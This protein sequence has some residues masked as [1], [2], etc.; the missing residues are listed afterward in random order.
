MVTYQTAAA[1]VL[2]IVLNL[3]LIPGYSYIG[4]SV[5]TVITEFFAF[6][7]LLYFTMKTKYR[8]SRKSIY[9]IIK[10]LISGPL[11]LVLFLG[12]KIDTLIS[13]AIFFILYPFIIYLLRVLD[14]DDIIILKKLIGK[15]SG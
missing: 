2:N 14:E 9:D 6:L 13:V 7:F 8:L 3:L 1:A 15:K 5:A 12:F 10:I 4:A 11:I